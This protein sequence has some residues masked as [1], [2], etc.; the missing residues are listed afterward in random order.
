MIALPD[1]QSEREQ[2]LDHKKEL[3]NRLDNLN[4]SLSKEET[5]NNIFIGILVIVGIIIIMLM[6]WNPSSGTPTTP[7]T[8]DNTLP[9]VEEVN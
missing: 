5:K 4:K 9:A 3:Q 8:S 2:L 6:F 1:H 7:A